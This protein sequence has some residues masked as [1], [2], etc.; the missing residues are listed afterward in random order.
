MGKYSRLGS[1]QMLTSVLC[2]QGEKV[3]QNDEFTRD[4]FRFLQLLC[5]GHNSGKWN[6]LTYH[7]GAKLWF[8]SGCHIQYNQV[9]TQ[10][11][12]FIHS[13]EEALCKVTFNPRLML[14]ST[15]KAKL[16]PES[17]HGETKHPTLSVKSLG[18][19]SV[20][21]GKGGLRA[22]VCPAGDTRTQT[23]C[24]CRALHIVH[25]FWV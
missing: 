18:P 1:K 13:Q 20:D 17:S 9:L 3:L 2:F 22:A 7:S 14:F 19:V 8:S 15:T 24:P 23:G 16:L 25:V 12:Q 6:R 4:L 21:T 5:E 10:G 11:Q